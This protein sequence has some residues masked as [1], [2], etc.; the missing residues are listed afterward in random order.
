MKYLIFLIFLGA[1]AYI[2]T[3]TLT[4]R[5]LGK[6]DLMTRKGTENG[7]FLAKNSSYTCGRSSSRSR[8]K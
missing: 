1:G 2:G 8:G 6:Y 7:R 5:V 4:E 3:Q